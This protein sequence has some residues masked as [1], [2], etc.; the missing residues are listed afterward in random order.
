MKTQLTV[1]EAR[2]IIIVVAG[3]NPRDTIGTMLY[4]LRKAG[5]LKQSAIEEVREYFNDSKRIHQNEPYSQLKFD[6]F[7]DL[8][9]AAYKELEEKVID[10]EDTKK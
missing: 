2:E 6:V 9:E 10:N 4:N 3:A 1:D 5:Y 8:W 7:N